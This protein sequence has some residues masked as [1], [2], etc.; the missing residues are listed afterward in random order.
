ME[1]WDIVAK[2]KA[3]RYRRDILKEL[4]NNKMTPSELAEVTKINIS[5]VSI[6]LRELQDIGLIELLTSED[7]KKGRI[8]SITEK[9][10]KILEKVK[11]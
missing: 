7:I 8:Y 3:S 6:S 5:H 10:K 11:K 2:I 4:S 1:I 9:G